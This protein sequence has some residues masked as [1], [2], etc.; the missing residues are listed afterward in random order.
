[1]TTTNDRPALS[2]ERVLHI[3]NSALVLQHKISGHEPQDG[4]DIEMD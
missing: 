4:L 2:S 3:N 1:M